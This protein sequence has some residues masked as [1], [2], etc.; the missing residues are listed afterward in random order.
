MEHNHDVKMTFCLF[1]P[2]EGMFTAV[3]CK[4]QR[5]VGNIWIEGWANIM[6]HVK[7]HS[8]WV[9]SHMHFISYHTSVLGKRKLILLGT[10][11][12][13]NP[14]L[15][16]L[17]H[18]HVT[19]MYVASFIWTSTKN[20]RNAQKTIWSWVFGPSFYLVIWCKAQ[21]CCPHSISFCYY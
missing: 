9:K 2:L 5:M 11:G 4:C 13:H 21:R 10:R 7:S 1:W 16:V 14:K 15:Q 12:A 3:H 6:C 8:L 17:L 20:E 18:I 19:Y